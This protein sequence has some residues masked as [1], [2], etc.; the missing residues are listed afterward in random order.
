MKSISITIITNRTTSTNTT[1]IISI[2][3]APQIGKSEG[4]FYFIL[5]TPNDRVSL[6]LS[7][8]LSPLFTSSKTWFVFAAQLHISQHFLFSAGVLL[9]RVLRRSLLS[10]SRRASD[11]TGPKGR[12]TSASGRPL[13]QRPQET[14]F[15]VEAVYIDS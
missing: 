8:W 7:R 6:P 2:T 13:P 1:P 5:T 12:A 11:S 4:D 9:L 15:W 14:L 3:I 10:R